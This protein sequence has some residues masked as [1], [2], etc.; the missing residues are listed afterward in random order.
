MSRRQLNPSPSS[1]AVCLWKVFPQFYWRAERRPSS[2][3]ADYQSNRRNVTDD[4][5]GIILLQRR[6]W[7]ANER[8]KDPDKSNADSFFSRSGLAG[9]RFLNAVV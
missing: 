5:L 2:L 4:V 7:S 6:T 8:K 1:A 3:I 9:P